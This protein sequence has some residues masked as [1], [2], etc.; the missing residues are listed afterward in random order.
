MRKKILLSLILFSL[1]KIGFALKP[2]TTYS[3]KPE[4]YGLMYKDY[5]VKTKDNYLINVW[6]YPAQKALSNDSMRYYFNKKTEI[7]PFKLSN[8]NKKP[9]I[10]ICDGDAQNMS[11][12]LLSFAYMY[13]TNGFNVITFDWRGFGK[14]QYFPIDTNYLVY[15]E[16]I[17][18][19]LAVIDFSTKIETVD[20]NRIGVF[21][22]STGAFLSYAV[23][24]KSDKVK[25]IIARGIFTDYASIKANLIKNNPKKTYLLYPKN[26]DKFSP[27]H[28]WNDFS[29]PI[30]LIVGDLDETTPKKNSIEIISNVKSNVRELW[31]VK[32]AKHGGINAPEIVENKLFIKKTV[33]FFNE[34]L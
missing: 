27:R 12:P 18:D 5:K 31:I 14:S 23:A 22:F 7:R 17:T 24:Y 1:L 9:T 34:N 11:N 26:I 28:T 16:F 30:F 29:K 10:I 25:A 13:C 2:D 21:G 4:I 3:L 32:N 6:F 19:Y 8:D 33:R 15:S 20:E